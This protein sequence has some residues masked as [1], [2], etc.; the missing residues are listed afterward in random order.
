M[1]RLLCY[2]TVSPLLL[3]ALLMLLWPQRYVCKLSL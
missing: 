3:P 1:V 2:L